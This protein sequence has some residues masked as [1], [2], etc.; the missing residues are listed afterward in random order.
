MKHGLLLFQF[1]KYLIFNYFKKIH[2]LGRTSKAILWSF[3]Q[4]LNKQRRLEIKNKIPVVFELKPS[5]LLE[6][7][8]DNIILIKTMKAC[9]SIVFHQP[10]FAYLL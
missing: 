9:I 1:L 5:I 4:L 3:L 10:I 8:L 6:S 2:L 7:D